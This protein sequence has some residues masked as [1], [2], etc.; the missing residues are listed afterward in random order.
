MLITEL[1][2]VED[3]HQAVLDDLIT[4]RTHPGYPELRILCYTAAAAFGSV[5]NDVTTNCRGLVYNAET[6]EVVA[7]PWKKFFNYG[8]SQA[9]TIADN[10]PV[11][12]TDKADGSLIIVFQYKGK[13]LATTKGSFASDQAF[14]AQILLDKMISNHPFPDFYRNY[15]LLF[16]YISPENRIV[17]DYGNICE[18]RLLG[19]VHINSYTLYGPNELVKYPFASRTQ[20]FPVSTLKQAL[21]I[22]DRKNAEGIVI[23]TSNGLM[24]KIKQ[25]DY[26]FLHKIITELTTKNLWEALRDGVVDNLLESVPDELFDDVSAELEKLN[27]AKIELEDSLVKAQAQIVEENNLPKDLTFD[28]QQR[29]VFA[30]EASKYPDTSLLIAMTLSNKPYGRG[31]WEKLKPTEN[32]TIGFYA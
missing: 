18:L 21:E 15:T 22:A 20:V 26:I 10:A 11:E 16:E 9:P 17:V 13:Y 29:K 27:R 8:Q 14:Q 24:V 3:L 31:F 32:K 23:R 5:W 12:V 30:I 7:R 1:F 28:A 25:E 19:A 4:E 2:S 6:L